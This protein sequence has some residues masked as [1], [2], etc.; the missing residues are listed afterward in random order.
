IDETTVAVLVEPIQGEAGVLIPH[1]DYLPQLRRI[2]TE[3]NV[4]LV[5]DEIQ[6]GLGRTGATLT[7]QQAGIQADLTTLGKALGG[8]IVASS[9]VVGRGDVH[10]VLTPGT[11]GSTFGGN[12]MACEVGLAVAGMMHTGSIQVRASRQH[13]VLA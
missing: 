7:Q 13:P 5:L 10:G 12:Q 2:C 3:R 4:L 8:G 11:H 9:A 6:S 1:E